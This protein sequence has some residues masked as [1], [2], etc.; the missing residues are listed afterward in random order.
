MTLTVV[1]GAT[2]GILNDEALVET[3]RAGSIQV[4]NILMLHT[5]QLLH[6]IVKLINLLAG[7]VINLLRSI[8]AEEGD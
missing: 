7:T 5:C 3:G 6:F 1:Q 2:I 8:T 4:D